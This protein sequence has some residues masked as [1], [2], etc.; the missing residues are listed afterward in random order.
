MFENGIRFKMAGEQLQESESFYR[1]LIAHSLD[2]IAM[3]DASGRITYSGPSIKKIS[4]YEPESLLGRHFAEFV[5]PDD[6][7]AA[8]EAFTLE[9]NKQSV[10]NYIHLRLKHSN[11]NWVWCN[12]R[13][14]SLI[15][16]PS[17]QSFVIYFTDV[18]KIK[19][20]EDKLRTSEE[21][22]RNLIQNLGQG[23]VIQNKNAELI[24]YNR[25][26]QNIL[27]LSEDQLI[28]TSSYDRRWNTITEDGQE[29]PGHDHPGPKAIRT[30]KP[31][32][33]VVMGLYKEATNERIWLLVSADPSLD[34]DGNVINVI[35]SFTDITEQKRLSG[36]LVEQEIQ[37][38]KQLT[39]ATIFG[40]EKERR[41]IGKELHD[42][43]NQ[44]LTTTRLYLEVAMEKAAGEVKEM[45][46]LSHKSLTDTINEIRLMSQSLVPPTLG[47]LGLIESVQDLCDALKRAHTFS[48]DF[49]YRYFNEDNLP[50]ELRLILFRIVQEQIN[51]IIRHANATH[52]QIKL[53][54][55]AEHIILTIADNGHGFDKKS[56]KKGLGFSNIR[57]RAD[58][59]NGKV[60]IE[61]A[62]GKGC[63][64]TV[65]IPQAPDEPDRINNIY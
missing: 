41:E 46:S 18:S 39:Q 30:K 8:A 23:I 27:G 54:S 2:G 21:L 4:G 49:N 40:Q 56:I 61:S 60:E 36:Q 57:N 50:G 51:N 29:I 9:I 55:D 38:Q 48:V 53:Q 12:V 45:I 14:H 37:K 47:D 13:G 42:N 26:A 15:D 65:N 62:P 19:E 35:I 22:F 17:L 44:H 59:F 28:G 6:L 58:L 24:L 16:K 1:N 11:G 63:I 25:A 10:L 43:I 5:H 7:P 32:K 31:V 64:L 33:D 52:I 3:T 20:A 34:D